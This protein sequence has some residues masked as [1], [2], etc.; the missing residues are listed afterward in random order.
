[1]SAAR[2]RSDR[3]L[4][5]FDF[6]PTRL[7]S[8]TT[9]VAPYEKKLRLPS[10]LARFVLGRLEWFPRGVSRECARRVR[11][12]RV[13]HVCVSVD[14][15]RDGDD[16]DDGVWVASGP[17]LAS[18]VARVVPARTRRPRRPGAHSP[19]SP[20]RRSLAVLV[21]LLLRDEVGGADGGGGDLREGAG[22]SR[23]S[24]ACTF[25]ARGR[26][27]VSTVAAPR[28]ARGATARGS[29]RTRKTRKQRRRRRG[30]ARTVERARRTVAPTKPDKRR[31]LSLDPFFS[32][33]AR[34]VAGRGA[35]SRRRGC[36]AGVWCVS[37]GRDGRRRRIRVRRYG[38][39]PVGLATSEGW[40]GSANQN[41]MAVACD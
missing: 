8:L 3:F 13:S 27:G 12:S 23:V 37:R 39:D 30:G 38:S 10:S 22:S 33:P 20:S 21:V 40:D 5:F 35:R 6:R 4:F 9:R 26:C 31:V 34:S 18:G 2:S 1:M 19:S 14:E 25:H 28:T 17:R 41:A 16:G 24:P 29:S 15:V 36:P 32:A 11:G 7:R